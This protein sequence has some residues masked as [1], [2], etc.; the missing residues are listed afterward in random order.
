VSTTFDEDESNTPQLVALKEMKDEAR[1]LEDEKLDDE[2][3]LK[4]EE[5]LIKQQAALGADHPDTH[6]TLHSIMRVIDAIN[7]S[8]GEQYNRT[9]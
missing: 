2:A 9:R 7:C 6:E 5:L 8:G 3:H 1:R 4:C